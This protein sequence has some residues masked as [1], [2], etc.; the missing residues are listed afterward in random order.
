MGG[1][2]RQR[3]GEDNGI[4]HHS[5]CLRFTYDSTLLRSHDLHPHRYG[6]AQARDASEL[7]PGLLRGGSYTE[8]APLLVSSP[9]PVL[10]EARRHPAAY[11]ATASGGERRPSGH[12]GGRR[13]P[14]PQVLLS[15][16][17][18]PAAEILRMRQLN[19]RS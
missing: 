15:K 4:D 9:A 8:Q 12:S 13:Y 18:N 16:S 5:I 10:P 7:P 19:R 2:D 17:A 1:A 3:A 6:D 11:P 14:A